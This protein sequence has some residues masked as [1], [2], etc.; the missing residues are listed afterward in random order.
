MQH[1]TATV[2]KVVKKYTVKDGVEKESI[3]F[4]VKLKSNSEFNDGDAVAVVLL[5]DFDGLDNVSADE[6]QQLNNAVAD[7]DETIAAN[8]ESIDKLNAELHDK[9]NLINDV[10]AKLKASEKTIAE[11]ESDISAKAD[12]IAELKSDGKVADATITGLKN[13]VADKD[14]KLTA[15]ETTIKDNEKTIA[16]LSA[17]NDALHERLDELSDLLSGKDETIAALDE[18]VVNCKI[19]VAELN[20]VDVDKLKEKADKVDAVTDEL[21]DVTKKL[22]GKSNVISLLQNQIM[23]LQQLVNYKDKEIDALENKGVLDTLFKKDV[24]ADIDSPTLYLI[25]SS[26]NL[27]KEKDDIDVDATDVA[28]DHVEN[29]DDSGDDTLTII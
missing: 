6:I 17:M 2:K 7:K 24:T 1:E 14:A 16:E 19:K 21:I 8:K 29:D 11:L 5:D 20:A 28:D 22:D 15:S 26:G 23:E 3:S 9:F 12:I 18:S 27:I 13:N 25:D 4:N 10:T